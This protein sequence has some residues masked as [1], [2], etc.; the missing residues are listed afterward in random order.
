M[1]DLNYRQHTQYLQ[2]LSELEK[3]KTQ[4]EIDRLKEKFFSIDEYA[5]LMGLLPEQGS[6]EFSSYKMSLAHEADSQKSDFKF[7]F[8]ED[9]KQIPSLSKTGEAKHTV[10]DFLKQAK[11]C[12][13]YDEY[14]RLYQEQFNFQQAVIRQVNRETTALFLD[15]DSLPTLTVLNSPENN[16]ALTRQAVQ[17]GFNPFSVPTPQEIRENGMDYL[18]DEIRR[19]ESSY[20]EEALSQDAVTGNTIGEGEF[21]EEDYEELIE[22]HESPTISV[23]S[24]PAWPPLSNDNEFFI[25]WNNMSEEERKSASEAR[26]AAYIQK[27]NDLAEQGIGSQKELD[28][29]L[30]QHSIDDTTGASPFMKPYGENNLL[31]LLRVK[32][33]FERAYPALAQ[34][35]G[36]KTDN[37]INDEVVP[38]IQPEADYSENGY[39]PPQEEKPQTLQEA[40][41]FFI[42]HAYESGTL[43]PTLGL[44]NY[45]TGHITL[46][47]GYEFSRTEDAGQTVVLSKMNA[48]NERVF[49]RV[50]DSFYKEA[51]NNSQIIA[52]A[53]KLTKDITQRYYQAAELDEETQR[54]NT[55]E[56]FW[57]NYKA[58]VIAECNNKQEAMQFA[59]N[60]IKRMGAEERR[61]FFVMAKK[62][63]S[64]KDESG[65]SLSYDKRILDYY[66]EATRGMTI[67]NRNI[68][69]EYK[70]PA[71]NV[72]DAIKQNTEI[73]DREGT[74]I[75]RSINMRVGDFIKVRL[76]IDS[77]TAQRSIKLPPTDFKIV[78]YSKDNNSIALISKDGKQKYI[79]PLDDFIAMAQKL[80][81]KLEQKQRKEYWENSME[82]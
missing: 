22:A 62:Y 26:K 8:G 52:K 58:G 6:G 23:P 37:E 66:E 17:A 16:A 39:Q 5:F 75:N 36:Q 49:F 41:Q 71:L 12:K 74:P 40:H 21:P 31:N 38:D 25:G 43:V 56:N 1:K 24:V 60:L 61:K 4:E 7:I 81:K 29:W 51:M 55:A 28:E 65:K 44:R 57:H 82:M 45:Q 70:T 3:C 72:F 32:Q 80:E 15:A 19:I 78:A 50:S 30:V 77:P 67:K 64:I 27:Q 48:E 76:T 34:R 18:L 11:D 10:E 9:F 68:F 59:Q 2:F 79:K 47:R 33:E 69:R 53:Q 35:K 13:D 63:E 54:D 46:V 20:N 42:E 73:F 14:E